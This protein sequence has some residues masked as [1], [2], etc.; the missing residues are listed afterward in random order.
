MEKSE[1]RWARLMGVG[2]HSKPIDIT[3]NPC[4]IGSGAENSVVIQGIPAMACALAKVDD[5][6]ADLTPFVDC[7][8]VNDKPVTA[9]VPAKIYSGDMLSLDKKTKGQSGQPL[10][11]I[12]MLVHDHLKR[13]TVPDAAIE[14]PATR[15]L[16]AK[17]CSA[18]EQQLKPAVDDQSGGLSDELSCGICL[19]LIHNCVTLVDCLHNFCGACISDWLKKGSC[20]LCK[21][22][23]SKAKKNV[24]IN[25]IV[26]SVVQKHPE[27]ARKEEEIKEMDCRDLFKN[28]H[29]VVLRKRERSLDSSGG[30][31]SRLLEIS[32]S[33][34]DDFEFYSED[35]SENEED[36]DYFECPECS[37]P[38]EEDGFQCAEDQHHEIC[39]SCEREMPNRVNTHAQRC[40]VCTNFYCGIY[41]A[42]C[43]GDIQLRRL[44]DHAPP[45]LL[46]DQI[47][48][49]NQYDLAVGSPKVRLCGHT[50]SRRTSRRS[51]SGTT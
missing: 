44:K 29:E 11:F 51:T 6:S 9:S 27:K 45:A 23:I 47:F 32:N 14:K 19:E 18:N 10:T 26:A 21:H 28:K 41:F 46:S 42:D 35:Y 25:N 50:C 12:F 43:R 20:P 7:M 38:R 3:H 17:P 33:L 2:G 1:N 40:E 5:F 31:F 4:T 34:D 30:I 16:T 22:S 48:R 13:P 36:S 8:E 37:Q 49:G 24:Q 15:V 39:R